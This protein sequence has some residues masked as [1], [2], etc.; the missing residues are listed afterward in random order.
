MAGL[1]LAVALL[2]VAL[3]VALRWQATSYPPP[4]FVVGIDFG[5]DWSSAYLTFMAEERIAMSLNNPK[6]IVLVTG[7]SW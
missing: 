3:F 6:A 7:V 2:A 1:I 4:R 5:R